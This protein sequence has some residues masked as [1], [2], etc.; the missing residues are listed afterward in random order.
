MTAQNV[1]A[2]AA[3]VTVEQM[4]NDFMKAPSVDAAMMFGYKE[5]NELIEG[6]KKLKAC[7]ETFNTLSKQIDGAQESIRVKQ[8]AMA[9][10][11][12]TA[13]DDDAKELVDEMAPVIDSYDAALAQAE[14]VTAAQKAIVARME[15]KNDATSVSIKEA[16]KTSCWVPYLAEKQAEKAAVCTAAKAT[17]DETKKIRSEAG[18]LYV[19][20]A[21]L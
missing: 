15:S 19:K 11:E 20:A 13:V 6:E 7:T 8:Y 21:A 17:L 4:V 16:F 3:K 12:L 5:A 14:T 2:E 18:V 9:R 10:A 1:T